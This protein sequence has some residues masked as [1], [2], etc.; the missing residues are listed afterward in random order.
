MFYQEVDFIV[1][2]TYRDTN[3]D[4]DPCIF[5]ICG[6]ILAMSSM[7]G[8]MDMAKHYTME[9]SDSGLPYPVA[10]AA[11]SSPFDMKE[12]KVCPHCRGSLRDVARYGRIVRRAVLDES[13]KRFINWARQ[14]HGDLAQK[15][16]AHKSQL[17]DD[18]AGKLYLMRHRGT[19]DGKGKTKKSFA[20]KTRSNL[21]AELLMSTDAS[22]HESLLVTRN[23]IARFCAQVTADEQ[24]FRRVADLVQFAH[25]RRAASSTEGGSDFHFDESVIQIGSSLHATVLLM[26]FD[27]H[28]LEC[29]VYALEKLTEVDKVHARIRGH[30][31]IAQDSVDSFTAAI[32]IIAKAFK[33]DRFIALLNEFDAT[34]AAAKLAKYTQQ[35]VAGAICSAHLCIVLWKLADF[36]GDD[37]NGAKD[38]E[39][40]VPGLTTNEAVGSVSSSTALSRNKL[41]ELAGRYVDTARKLLEASPSSTDLFGTEVDHLETALTNFVEY[42]PV[43]AAEMQAVYQAMAAKFHGTGHWYTCANGHPFT[44]GE[45]GMPM[46]QTR[47]P[48]CGATVG[49]LNHS[50]AEGVAR[51][52][53]IERLGQ[54]METLAIE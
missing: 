52:V 36:A 48:E 21:V 28:A 22:R 35:E 13:T 23:E 54:G 51:A 33:A 6:H 15:L 4:E 25:N 9:T 19:D 7:D 31:I 38:K 17:E 43:T 37:D 26:R 16:M 10:L 5:P 39:T 1:M 8:I 34:T 20:I 50:P 42:Q 46:E 30:R 18:K 14:K 3:L 29:A 40:A 24:P 49:G 12:V 47:C 41:K 32:Q 45:C 11:S 27:I 2:S 44:V 53:D